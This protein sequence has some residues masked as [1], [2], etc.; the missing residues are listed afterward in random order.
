M[1]YTTSTKKNLVIT[2]IMLLDNL[3]IPLYEC[4]GIK[5]RLNTIQY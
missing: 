3:T 1:G 5:S 4:A 2:I